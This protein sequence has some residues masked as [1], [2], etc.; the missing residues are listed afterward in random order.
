MRQNNNWFCLPDYS[1][2]NHTLKF[3]RQSRTRDVY[4]SIKDNDKIPPGAY[5]GGIVFILALGVLLLIGHD[6]GF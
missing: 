4:H 5:V 6:A 3:S 2:Q 1:S